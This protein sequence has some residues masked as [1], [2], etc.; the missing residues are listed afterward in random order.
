[1][2]NTIKSQKQCPLC[3]EVGVQIIQS[4]NVDNIVKKYKDEYQISVQ[5]FFKDLDEVHLCECPHDGYKFFYPLDISGDGSFYEQ[6]QSFSWYYM[7]WK[8]EHQ[9]VFNLINGNHSSKVLEI[10]CAQGSFVK[11]LKENG[12][13]AVGLELNQDAVEIANGEGLEVYNETI[14]NHAISGKGKYDIVCSFQVMEHIADIKEVLTAAVDAL[15]IGGRMVI[16]VPN[17]CS[18]LFLDKWNTLN[19][20][21]HHMNHWD[22]NS[23]HN[24]ERLLPVKTVGF[25]LEPQQD[26]HKA[27]FNGVLNKHI[28][29]EI[30]DKR[31][32]L[33]RYCGYRL[34]K[35]FLPILKQYLIRKL[36]RKY[37]EVE[38]VTIVG[39][40]EKTK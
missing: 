17:N 25:L 14:Q 9:V 35:H 4:Y 22:R 6:L 20:P 10:G 13:T 21:P 12:H 34:S 24:L 29:Q 2:N 40:F 38:N 18:H 16:S 7:P 32:L 28:N 3:G 15:K 39:I 33:E 5:R 19:L 36:Y 26:Y 23:L 31:K 11:K 1:M 8:W 37:P 30:A 27:W